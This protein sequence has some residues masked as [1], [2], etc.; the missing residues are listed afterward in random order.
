L[1]PGERLANWHAH[2]IILAALGAFVAA[3]AF[4]HL[5]QD[6]GEWDI[7]G[8]HP[9]LGAYVTLGAGLL[10]VVCGYLAYRDRSPVPARP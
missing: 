9:G 4:V 5:L 2:G 6:G 8:G 3:F 7:P 10:M 1:P